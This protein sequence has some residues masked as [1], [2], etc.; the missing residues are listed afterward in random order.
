MSVTDY[1]S[2]TEKKYKPTKW[3]KFVESIDIISK[4][5]TSSDSDDKKEG[6]L[7][8]FWKKDWLDRNAASTTSMRVVREKHKPI[9]KSLASSPRFDIAKTHLTRCF[10]TKPLDRKKSPTID[11]NLVKLM[12]LSK[13]RSS[14]PTTK[15]LAQKRISELRESGAKTDSENDD[16]FF[17]ELPKKRRVDSKVI[18]STPD[19]IIITETAPSIERFRRYSS[20][21]DDVFDLEYR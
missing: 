10:D 15:C 4:D 8:F 1:S 19:N 14:T 18:C 20:S 13:R 9:S 21:S 6:F 2:K 11:D 7:D 17:K 5:H 12:S 3:D 16:V